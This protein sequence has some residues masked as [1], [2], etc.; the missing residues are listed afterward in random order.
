MYDLTDERRVTRE[1]QRYLLELS[2]ATAELSHIAVDGIYGEETRQAVSRFQERSG[3]PITGQADPRT[4]EEI[5]RQFYAAREART[6]RPI[7]LPAKSL[8]LALHARGSEVMLLQTVL[9]ALREHIQEIPPLGQSGH[10]NTETQRALRAYQIHRRLPPSGILD[11]ETWAMLAAD[12]Q[13]RAA[14][15]RYAG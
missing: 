5:Y 10:F 14:I 7:L 4:W 13:D 1:L 11:D 2:Y 6:A 8:P 12:Y 3:L 9:S 15:P